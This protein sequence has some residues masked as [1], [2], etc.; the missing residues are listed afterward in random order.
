MQI[1]LGSDPSCKT[2]ELNLATQPISRARPLLTF[3]SDY[4]NGRADGAIVVFAVALKQPRHNM[5]FPVL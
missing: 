1:G 5:L 3:I 4:Q 2:T